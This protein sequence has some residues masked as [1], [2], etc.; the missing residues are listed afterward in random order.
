MTFRE[1]FLHDLDNAIESK[2]PTII[3]IC[4]EEGGDGVIVSGM[5][6]DK[7]CDICPVTG[8]SLPTAMVRI[9]TIFG[10]LNTY[11]ICNDCFNKWRQFLQKRYM[12]EDN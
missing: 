1:Q 11:V 7:K 6:M 5:W 12:F 8:Y 4:R 3:V 10:K 9:R 2:W